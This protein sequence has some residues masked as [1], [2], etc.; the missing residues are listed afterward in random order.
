MT[1]WLDFNIQSHTAIPIWTQI[2][3]GTKFD[4]LASIIVFYYVTDLKL[5]ND[6]CD[7]LLG[8]EINVDILI[9]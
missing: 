4:N 9:L 3:T 1:I 8:V 5:M 2:I 7:N 6:A